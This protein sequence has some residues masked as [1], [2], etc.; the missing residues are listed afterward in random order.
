[1]RQVAVIGGGVAGMTAAVFAAE[2]GA[3]VTII[4]QKERVGKK[5]L[6]T[7]NGRCNFTNRFQSPECYRSDQPDFP[8]TVIQAFDEK[9]VTAFFERMGIYPKDR[10]GYLYPNSDQA[11]SVLDAF[12]MECRRLH[13]RILSDTKCLHILPKGNGF[14][15]VT[16]KG[17]VRADAVVLAAGSKAAPATGSDG[18]GYSLA[19][20]LGHRLIPVLPALVQLRCREK[21]YKSISG[22]RVHANVSLYTEG[23]AVA[24]DTGE[25]QLTNYGISGIPVFQVSRFASR[26][27]Y[28]KKHVK[29]VLNFMPEFTE[30]ELLTFLKERKKCR[31]EKT[32]EGFL[33]GVF[34]KKLI[35]LWLKQCDLKPDRTV[36]SLSEE[37]LCRI[38][39]RIQHFETIINGTNSYEQAQVCCG[40]IDT[41]ETNPYTMESLYIPGLHFAGEILDVDG[42][43]GG[44]NITFA[45]ASGAL[46][47]K[48]A[49]K[50]CGS[51][52]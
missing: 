12:R 4:E 51:I 23:E 39:D 37:E 35:D 11:S 29:A 32:A 13:I 5:I 15:L 14:R 6:S 30:E 48:G 50:C 33:V 3:E 16:S 26:G 17:N 21:F 28:E 25:V 27:L 45:V 9:Q 1:M 42:I 7:G 20:E 2:S 19:K 52:R 41:S 44:Y 47:G 46:A 18:S 10:N 49:A 34:H 22:V 24:S 31:P 43:C 36:R 38:A 40:G 8:W